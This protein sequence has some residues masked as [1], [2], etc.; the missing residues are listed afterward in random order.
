MGWFLAME[1]YL[2]ETFGYAVV[3]CFED[4]MVFLG[5]GV[6]FMF[7]TLLLCGRAFLKLN[8]TEDLG[9]EEVTLIKVLKNNGKRIYA[10]NPKSLIEATEILL[11][12]IFKP[13]GTKNEYTMRDERRTKKIIMVWVIIEIIIV[14]FAVFS[15]S[16]VYFPVS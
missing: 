1:S 2:G 15:I 9:N 10:A 5:G 6:V 4:L 8:K 16:T 12:V 14:I 13:L 3:V 7:I 11:L